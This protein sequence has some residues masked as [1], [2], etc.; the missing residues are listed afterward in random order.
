MEVQVSVYQ[1]YGTIMAC[2]GIGASE[3]VQQTLACA[4]FHMAV[5]TNRGGVL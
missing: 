2:Q 1:Q 3:H 5:F 4:E